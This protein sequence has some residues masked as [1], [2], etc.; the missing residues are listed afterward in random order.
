MLSDS[1]P[2]RDVEWTAAGAEA[3]AR[4][5]ARVWRL[6]EAFEAERDS[7]G[8]DAA[9]PPGEEATAL[10]RAAHRAIAD[11]TEGIEGFAFNKAIARLYE[12]TNMLA[13]VSGTTPDVRAA[14]RF[15]LRALAQLMAPMT[16]HLAEEMWAALG[17]DGLIARA[18][19]PVADPDMLVVGSVTLP[20]QINGKR[21]AEIIAPAGLGAA[22][23]EA[24]VLADPAVRRALGGAVPRKVIVVPDRIV[25][26][27][28]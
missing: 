3:A 6:V 17:G 16:P 15:A 19:W 18:P 1:P 2:E 23:V 9:D 20:V 7:V 5:L 28:V 14:H 22:E 21:R 12:F 4:H 24:L 26:V 8:A 27:V 10:R 25:N 11:V 13:R